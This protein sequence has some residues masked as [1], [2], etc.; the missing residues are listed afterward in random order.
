M[1]VGS[2]AWYLQHEYDLGAI[3]GRTRAGRILRMPPHDDIELQISLPLQKESRDVLGCLAFNGLQRPWPAMEL[4]TLALLEAERRF[5]RKP[6]QASRNALNYIERCFDD[7]SCEPIPWLGDA[8]KAIAPLHGVFQKSKGLA[9]IYFVLIQ[10]KHQSN[11]NS[12]VYVGSTTISR[13]GDCNNRQAARIG[14]HFTGVKSSRVVRERG[15]EPL[16]SLNCFLSHVAA[17]QRYEAESEAHRA[18]E[19]CG[20]RVFGDIPDTAT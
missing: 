16:W 5:S 4:A 8:R 17:S 3:G 1:Y 15:V 11:N 20:L 18:L 14:Q 12:G 2:A 6:R 9:S 7:V 13:L 19:A 10:P